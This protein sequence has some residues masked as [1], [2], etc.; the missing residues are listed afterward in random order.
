MKIGVFS[1]KVGNPMLVSELYK[2]CY[3]LGTCDVLNI[4]K[5]PLNFTEYPLWKDKKLKQYEIFTENSDKY[6]S[7]QEFY[8]DIDVSDL[9]D[10][11]LFYVMMPYCNQYTDNKVNN[12]GHFSD[13][14]HK[15]G[16]HFISIGK[17]LAPLIILSKASELYNIPIKQFN[18][19]VGCL[20][21]LQFGMKPF[22]YE[23]FH[24]YEYKDLK[25]CTSLPYYYTHKPVDEFFVSDAPEK[26]I[27]L[28][29]HCYCFENA[30][31][32][33]QQALTSLDTIASKFKNTDIVLLK[34]K[35]QAIPRD[36]YYQKIER[37]KYTYVVPSFIS[38]VFSIDRF[39]D[40]IYKDCLP[41][42]SN[43]ANVTDISKTF[44]Y[45]FE[46]LKVKNFNY[47][48]S[49]RLE[50]LDKIKKSF[51]EHNSLPVGPF[52]AN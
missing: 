9:K 15:I 2:H 3:Y 43:E 39:Q 6:N 41:I 22:E 30:P 1:N 38:T 37:S 28:T 40:S 36:A 51:L 27:D 48:E 42:I 49:F 19:E 10:Y 5:K 34:D 7:W 12:R 16:L 23:R 50:Q 24:G 44:D 4:F 20:D 32:A 29:F 18:Y 14:S 47:S 52:C 11:D 45:D 8:D 13:L 21:L 46:K 25:L 35:T 26:D 31:T 33:R 17:E